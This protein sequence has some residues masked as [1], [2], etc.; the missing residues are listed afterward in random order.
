[1]RFL[2][3]AVNFF[4]QGFKKIFSLILFNPGR[5]YTLKK[6]FSSS[7][8]PRD[9]FDSLSQIMPYLYIMLGRFRKPVCSFFCPDCA[10][11]A[12]PPMVC[13]FVW[14][15]CASCA[16]PTSVCLFV[17]ENCASSA[18]PSQIL[19]P[20]YLYYIKYYIISNIISFI[21]NLCI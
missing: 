20:I 15:A 19:L 2:L 10:S 11:R 4:I 13:L 21:T 18:S 3:L 9:I 14:K 8:W 16:S 5:G 6:K 7:R 17:L 12:S 1:M